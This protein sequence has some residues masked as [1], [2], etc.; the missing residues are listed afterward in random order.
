MSSGAAPGSTSVWSIVFESSS[1]R[2]A[3]GLR[4]LRGSDADGVPDGLQFE[5]GGR[6]PRRLAL[7]VADDPLDVLGGE[8]LEFGPVTV[9]T[10]QVDRVHVHMRREHGR[11]LRL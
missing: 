10:G 4:S 2:G 8:T 3:I 5:V 11:E 7:A 1:R 6:V 9:D